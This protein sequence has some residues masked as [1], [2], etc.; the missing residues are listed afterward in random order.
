MDIYT[1]QADVRRVYHAG[2]PGNLIAAILWATATT[3]FQWVSPTAGMAVLFLGGMLIFPT[4]MLVITM[5]GGPARLPKGH[6]SASLGTQAALSVPLGLLIALVLG[7]FDPTLFFPAALIIVGAHY[8]VFVSMYGLRIFAVQAGT[9]VLL[10][11]VT[12]F[13]RP[14]LGVISGWL[15]AAIMLFFAIAG[16]PGRERALP[17]PRLERVRR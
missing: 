14:D 2:I 16:L 11:A 8:L 15:G 4:T 3:V 6:P 5:M 1:A 7:S 13:L 17:T 12:L 10:G 9:L